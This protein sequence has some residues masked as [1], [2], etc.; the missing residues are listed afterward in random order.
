[1]YIILSATEK[2][3]ELKIKIIGNKIDCVNDLN[4]LELI[5]NKHLN[6]KNHI[7]LGLGRPINTLNA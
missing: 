1:M 6:W 7:V 4:F 2:N 5:I 3:I